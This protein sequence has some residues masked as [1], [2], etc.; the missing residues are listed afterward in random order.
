MNYE[1]FTMNYEEFTKEEQKVINDFRDLIEEIKIGKNKS[2]IKFIYATHSDPFVRI[3]YIDI[4]SFVMVLSAFNGLN[5]ENSFKLLKFIQN[6]NYFL[7]KF[8]SYQ[9]Y[10]QNKH[11]YPFI[12]E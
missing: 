8:S 4:G 12:T 1:E 2:E 7:P 3:N 11:K 10:Q 9:D 5:S 6:K